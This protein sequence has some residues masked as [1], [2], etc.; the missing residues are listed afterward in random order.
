MN[1]K[2]T[3]KLHKHNGGG[4]GIKTHRREMRKNPEVKKKIYN[5]DLQVQ[6]VGP[7]SHFEVRRRRNIFH[8]FAK[9]YNNILE[10]WNDGIIILFTNCTT[11][12]LTGKNNNRK[13]KFVLAQNI[14][15][16]DIKVTR[17]QDTQ[18]I[19][20]IILRKPTSN[21]KIRIENSS[22]YNL[23]TVYDKLINLQT[24]EY[25]K[26]ESESSKTHTTRKIRLSTGLSS[27][28]SLSTDSPSSSSSSSKN[29]LLKTIK[30]FRK[31]ILK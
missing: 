30:K 5:Y 11:T 18:K 31:R 14:H 21:D 1:H 4:K 23:E 15:N 26:R 13:K 16:I 29:T 22:N 9:Y 7:P 12:D 6:E 8:R 19:N 20:Q 25:Y 27:S 24:S 2:L 3:H 17:S 10:I 28:Y